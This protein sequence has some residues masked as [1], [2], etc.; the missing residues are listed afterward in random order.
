M[1][2]CT[3]S[4]GTKSVAKMVA[5]PD[6]TADHIAGAARGHRG[7]RRWARGGLEPPRPCGHRNL[8]PARLPIPPLARDGG[9]RVTRA[10]SPFDSAPT[11]RTRDGTA[12][13]PGLRH[14]FRGMVR[15]SSM[16]L[17]DA[18]GTSARW[19]CDGGPSEMDEPPFESTSRV[20]RRT[21]RLPVSRRATANTQASR[22]PSNLAGELCVCR[23]R[24]SQPAR[25]VATREGPVQVEHGPRHDPAQTM[26]PGEEPRGQRGSGRRHPRYANQERIRGRTN[27]YHNRGHARPTA[28]VTLSVHIVKEPNPRRGVPSSRR[29]GYIADL[30]STNGTRWNGVAVSEHRLTDGDSITVGARSSASR[31]PYPESNHVPESDARPSSSSLPWRS[32]YLFFAPVGRVGGG[33][34]ARDGQAGNVGNGRA[35]RSRC[36][37]AGT[38]ALS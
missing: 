30:G 17:E 26:H 24:N 32:C 25:G 27:P 21:Q 38:A 16:E 1:T 3:G 29:P 5:R 13:N 10:P 35:R 14:A 18:P 36:A 33:E 20:A 12:A 23:S 37:D 7:Q 4:S 11:E 15:S 9:R 2:S 31:R 28:Q 6:A 8:N 19:S 34:P 22:D